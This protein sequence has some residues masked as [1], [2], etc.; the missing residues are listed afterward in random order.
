[1]NQ[2]AL[3]LEMDRIRGTAPGVSVRYLLE[4]AGKPEYPELTALE[5]EGRRRIRTAVSKT[6]HLA[7]YVRRTPKSTYWLAPGSD[8]FK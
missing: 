8:E 4:Y 7:G 6:L 5:I 1:M 2:E 3:L